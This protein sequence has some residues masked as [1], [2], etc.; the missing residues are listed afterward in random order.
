MDNVVPTN[1][2]ILIDR[3]E[4]PEGLLDWIRSRAHQ[5]AT[6]L[7]LLMP[8]PAHAEVHVLHPERHDHAAVALRGLHASRS[9]Y[10][11][12]AGAP[13]P[14]TASIRHDPFDAVERFLMTNTVDEIVVCVTHHA[15]SDRLRHD[16]AHR[17][18]HLHIP[19]TDITPANM[20]G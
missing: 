18:A 15:L 17:L 3:V 13:V 19:I 2:L 11:A 1:I 8:D 12:A 16:V 5:G 14:M 7:H 10:E 6:S 9:T 4:P 20:H